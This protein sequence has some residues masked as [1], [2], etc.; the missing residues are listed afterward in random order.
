[1]PRKPRNCPAG[2]PAVRV[3]PVYIQPALALAPMAGITSHPFRILAK[4]YGCG[5]VFSEMIHARALLHVGS[6]SSRLAYFHE[7]ERPVGLQLF[8]SEPKLLA[9]AAQ[10]AEA[11]GADLVDLNLGC[12]TPRIVRN[13]EGGLCCAARNAAPSSAVTAAR[14]PVT[15][16]MRKAGMTPG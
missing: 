11:L 10:K 1:M 15:V 7:A 9:A 2:P 16:K 8:G 6:Y 13:G 12:P 5:L 14:C 3:G 4:I